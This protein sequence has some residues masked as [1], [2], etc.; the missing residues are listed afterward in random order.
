VGRDPGGELYV[1]AA[2]GRE[3]GQDCVGGARRKQL[4]PAIGLGP[5]KRIQ[6]P[7]L[8]GVE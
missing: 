8:E 1:Y 5:A 4:D 3:Q 7:A 2:I 6:R